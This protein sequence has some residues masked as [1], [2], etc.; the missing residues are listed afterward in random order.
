MKEFRKDGKRFL[1]SVICILAVLLTACGG[2]AVPSSAKDYAGM[3]HELVRSELARAGFTAITEEAVSD[4]TSAESR[5][6]GTVISVSI[7]GDTEFA[8]GAKYSPSAKVVISYHELPKI[9]FPLTGEEIVSLTSEQL[10]ARLREAGFT[11]V[12]A[13]TVRD[14]DPDET[15]R[16]FENE[17]KINGKRIFRENEEIPFDAAITVI[18]H[19]PFEKYDVTLHVDYEANIVFGRY[20]IGVLVDGEMAGEMKNGEEKTFELRLKEGE[21]T[22]TFAK[23]GDSSVKGETTFTVGGSEERSYH[24]K[25]HTNY[26]D[27]FEETV[28]SVSGNGV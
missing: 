21:H 19:L 20:V 8:S 23:T 28:Q 24:L 25:S 3:D 2:T 16:A 9:A 15:D 27:V 26:I 7:G 5:Q 4:L 10:A 11:D 1:F 22:L 12:T 6:D 13:E 17:I 18:G 14:L